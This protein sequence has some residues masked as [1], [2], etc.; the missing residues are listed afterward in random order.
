MPRPRRRAPFHPRRAASL[1]LRTPGATRWSLYL[2]ALTLAGAGILAFVPQAV[3]RSHPATSLAMLLAVASCGVMAE[4]VWNMRPWQLRTLVGA[5]VAAA[6]FVLVGYVDG[7]WIHGTFPRE[8]RVL[9]MVMLAS[10]GL[11]FIHVR[12]PASVRG[13]PNPPP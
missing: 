10:L 12:L 11:L 5:A 9:G 13:G 3:Q 4:A 7:A 2:A 6:A 1:T 8:A